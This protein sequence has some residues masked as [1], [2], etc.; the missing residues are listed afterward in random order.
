MTTITPALRTTALPRSTVAV[1]A[2]AALAAAATGAMFG[3]GMQ[4]AVALVPVGCIAGAALLALALLRFELFVLVLLG[5]RS[6]LDLFAGAGSRVLE[7]ASL[8][9]GL[10]LLLGASYHFVNRAR[11]GALSP[12]SAVGWIFGVTC[13]F[14]VL[15]SRDVGG[16]IELVRIAG[17]LLML[18]TIE[19]LVRTDRA[20]TMLV[21]ALCG[22]TVVPLVVLAVQLATGT[23]ADLT[24]D[25][26]R[27]S[28][29]FNH[30]NSLGM[31]LAVVLVVGVAARRHVHF[32]FLDPLLVAAAAGL[33]LT[34]ARGAWI[35][36]LVGVG[37]VAL[38]N[39]PKI[40][41]VLGA[42]V[43]VVL[44][45]V[46]SVLGRATDVGDERNL[47]GTAGNSLVW[48]LDHWGEIVELADAP[49]IGIGLGRVAERS[50]SG[51]APH[52]DFLRVGVEAGIIG[53][54]AYLAFVGVVVRTA[55][56]ASRRAPT[57]FGRAVGDAALALSVGF[58]VL[59][60][61]SNLISQ[62]VVLWYFFAIFGASAGALYQRPPDRPELRESALTHGTR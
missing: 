14:G 61:T 21:A 45:S 22:A 57:A 3:T 27:Y 41:A 18:T 26:D 31:F 55:W 16:G 2:L 10:F 50:T 34:F 1:G 4:P 60:A 44:L 33:V 15:A 12:Q 7:P 59:S 13:T 58:I 35:A 9:G 8:I 62:V 48:R 20:R 42:G 19:R 46:P 56:A 38:R 51:V 49:V 37:I 52:N 32:W 47:S 11:L 24:G 6:G 23:A 30:P 53:L 5:I 28:G 43:F 40:L 17:A 25:V 54:V 29:S 36:A 39:N